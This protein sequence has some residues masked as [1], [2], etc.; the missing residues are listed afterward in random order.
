MDKVEEIIN[1]MKKIENLSNEEVE[2]I[3]NQM[4]IT[5]VNTLVNLLNEVG[6][7]K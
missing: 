4:D 2:A 3:I 7:D 5:D 1:G 6:G